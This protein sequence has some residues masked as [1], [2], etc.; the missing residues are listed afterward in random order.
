MFFRTFDLCVWSSLEQI[1][2][3]L[4]M[5]KYSKNCKIKWGL[6]KFIMSART[7]IKFTSYKLN[8]EARDNLP[9]QPRTKGK[10][11]NIYI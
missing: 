7:T 11:Q 2:L 4:F 8:S 6:E 10:E 5:H 3:S 1:M 9:A